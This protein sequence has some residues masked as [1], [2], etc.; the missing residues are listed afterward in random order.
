MG[1]T[2]WISQHECGEWIMWDQEPHYVYAKSG[3]HEISEELHEQIRESE[4]V[5]GIH[6]DILESLDYDWTYADD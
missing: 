3:P 1:V 2:V 5:F 6:Q 4:R